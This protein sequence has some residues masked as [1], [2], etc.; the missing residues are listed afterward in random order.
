MYFSLFRNYLPLEK[1]RT[2]H[3]PSLVEIGL[4]VLEKKLKTW[5]LYDINDNDYDNRQMLI[6]ISEKLS[7]AFSSGEWKSFIY[8]PFLF[9]KTTKLV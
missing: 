4:V 9:K 2:L 6:N 3:L 7:W 1:D 8:T 5:K